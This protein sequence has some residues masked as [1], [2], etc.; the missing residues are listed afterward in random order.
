MPAEDAKED[1]KIIAVYR[2]KLSYLQEKH[3]NKINAGIVGIGGKVSRSIR[4]DLSLHKI[5]GADTHDP[6][7]KAYIKPDMIGDKDL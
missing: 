2:E 5:L 4:V 1:Q 3:R 7:I 6:D